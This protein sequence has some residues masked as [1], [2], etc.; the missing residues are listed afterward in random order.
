MRIR[1][2]K[3][4]ER[5]KAEEEEKKR[6]TRNRGEGREKDQRGKTGIRELTFR[7]GLSCP[8]LSEAATSK[9]KQRATQLKSCNKKS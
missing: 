7:S 6:N 5:N 8:L 4:I 9:L 2:W 3:R 1:E